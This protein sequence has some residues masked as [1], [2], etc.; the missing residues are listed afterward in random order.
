MSFAEF[1]YRIRSIKKA[2]EQSKK[3]AEL[4]S[5]IRELEKNVSL[6]LPSQSPL[7]SSSLAM[8]QRRMVAGENSNQQEEDLLP[9]AANVAR[10]IDLM[11]LEVELN[12]EECGVTLA[13]L[14]KEIAAEFSILSFIIKTSLQAQSFCR[15][16]KEPERLSILRSLALGSLELNRLVD[17]HPRPSFVLLA[18]SKL[19]YEKTLLYIQSLQKVWDSKRF[20]SPILSEHVEEAFRLLTLQT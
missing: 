8:D 16:E 6:P 4:I 17:P 5:A 15:E 3:R 1:Q 10:F 11:H 20:L 2:K 18:E 19:N 9:S 7:Y 13:F 14:I 12:M